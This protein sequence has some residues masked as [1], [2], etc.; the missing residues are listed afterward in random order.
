MLVITS[1]HASKSLCKISRQ[2]ASCLP[3]GR[4]YLRGERG[5][6]RFQALAQRQAD[7]AI[8]VLCSSASPSSSFIL[9]S[10]QFSC[11]IWKWAEEELEVF[12]FN[13]IE[14]KNPLGAKEPYEFEAK[15][16]AARKLAL[17]LGLKPHPLASFYK[18]LP[19]FLLKVAGKK[20]IYFAKLFFEKNQ[21]LS[22]SF[23]KRAL[24]PS[25]SGKP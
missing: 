11:G 16:S 4:F 24:F 12:D 10:R 19:K 3:N 23:K 8:L 13:Q 2:L 17:F 18:G 1:K 25:S 5:L 6:E 20:G 15:T 21:I 7:D 14:S 9:R 22:F